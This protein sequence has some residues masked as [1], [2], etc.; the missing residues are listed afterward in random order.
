MDDL[1]SVS[2]N[3]NG[4]ELLSVVAALHHQAIQT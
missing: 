2:N 1:E 4:E 3:A